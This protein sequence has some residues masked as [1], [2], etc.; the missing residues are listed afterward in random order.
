MILHGIGV[1]IITLSV[2]PACL[3]HQMLQQ[4][5][6]SHDG[7]ILQLLSANCHQETPCS[8][9]DE[10]AASLQTTVVNVEAQGL[11]SFHRATKTMLL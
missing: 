7:Y 4:V 5:S 11:L 8:P 9:P 2:C 10:I 3:L 1:V 6:I